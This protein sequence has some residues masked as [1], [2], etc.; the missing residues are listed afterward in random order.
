MIELVMTHTLK[1][2]GIAFLILALGLTFFWLVVLKAVARLA[3]RLGHASPCPA[4]FSWIVNN[5]VRRRY[6]RPILDRVGIRR[7]ERVLELGPGPG[8]FSLDAAR[9]L[10]ESGRLIAVD[11]Q[12]EMIAR[13]ER[14][15]REAGLTNIEAHTADAH[16]LPLPDASV[17]R[18]FLITVLPEIP[19]RAR[20]LAELRRVLKPGGTLS[21]T[22]EFLDPDYLFAPETIRLVESAGFHLAQ[23]YGGLWVYTLNFSTP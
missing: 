6:M 12:P 20:A 18:A 16:H 8:A 2:I 11:I 9:M 14:R 1:I 10:G 5:P 23:K 22:E 3:A 4:S 19:D 7:G 13:L 17:D 21:V 15:A